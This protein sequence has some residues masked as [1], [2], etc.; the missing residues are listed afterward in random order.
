MPSVG[1]D[2]RPL[3]RYGWCLPNAADSAACLGPHAGT[4][5]SCTG[6]P[7]P[8]G[9]LAPSAPLTTTAPATSLT[10]TA[11]SRHAYLP[12]AS[13]PSRGQRAPAQLPLQRQR[14]APPHPCS[15]SRRRWSLHLP[16]LMILWRRLRQ[17]R[18]WRRRRG[19]GCI[20]LR[21]ASPATGGSRT[22]QAP[23]AGR[24]A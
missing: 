10:T 4:A 8:G 5:R 7:A 23:C 18:Q 22:C 19:C 2:E 15:P 9:I 14:S 1:A 16:L 24:L 3:R 12:R 21:R 17:Q 6:Q 20:S 11:T 13:R